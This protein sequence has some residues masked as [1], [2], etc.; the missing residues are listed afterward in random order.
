MSD[1]HM[2]QLRK[3][4]FHSHILPRI[5]HGSSS[6]EETE[7]QL[8]LISS[9]YTDTVIATPHFYPNVHNVNQFLEDRKVALENIQKLSEKSKFG[10]RLGFGAE[11]F[12][13]G[14]MESM[15]DLDKLCIDG[16][17]VILLELPFFN[18]KEEVFDTVMSIHKLGYTVVLAHV[19]RYCQQY[20]K[21]L[22][23]LLAHGIKA[24][25]NAS[26]FLSSSERKG[27]FTHVDPDFIYA[28]GSDLHG[29][30]KNH[31]VPF[32]KITKRLG[33]LFDDVMDRSAMLL[34][35]ATF[36]DI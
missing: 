10:L 25:I 1:K 13:Y 3:I 7:C 12:V 8:K 2:E 14:N 24:Q 26:A 19:D 36:L 22:E 15:V 28:F 6:I 17:N 29:Y 16:T 27:I 31:Y 5:D 32:V 34:E 30:K 9:M 23:Y 18:A 4:D 35:G 20:G 21:Q 33:K 11:V